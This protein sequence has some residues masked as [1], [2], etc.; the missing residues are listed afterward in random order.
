[1]RFPCRRP[2]RNVVLAATLLCV[3]AAWGLDPHQSLRRYGYQSWQTDSGLPQNTVHAV[4]QTSDGYMWFATEAGLVRFDSVQ[5]TV[6]TRK[7]TPQ[8]ASDLIYSLMEDTS[9]T[10]WIGTAN[11]VASYLHG[12]F[13]AFPTTSGSTVWSLFQDREGRIWIATSSGL[14]RLDGSRVVNVPGIPPLDESS[15]MLEPG[16]GSLWLSTTEGLFHAAPGNATYFTLA[17]RAAQI[18]AVTLDR[19]GRVWAGTESGLEICSMA[20]CDAFPPLANK[21]VHALAETAQGGIWIG[22]DTGLSFYDPAQPQTQMRTYTGSDGLPSGRINLLFCDREGALWIG[23][24][25]GIARL[26]HEKIE[27]FTPREELF[28]QR[29]SRHRRRP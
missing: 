8:L 27:S 22:A 24:A 29:G 5:F 25:G 28:Q 19:K 4:L 7:N 1:M 12:A 6:F 16:D 23:T 17:G 11:G 3:A 10:L 20:A 13:H 15:R 21:E 2:F 14:M 18:Q 9:G 26:I